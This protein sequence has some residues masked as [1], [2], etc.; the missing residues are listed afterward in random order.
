[1]QNFALSRYGVK[2]LFYLVDPADRSHLILLLYLCFDRR[3]RDKDA[4]AL[5][6]KG[7]HQRTVIELGNHAWTD[8]ML[9]QPL[10][11]AGA[12]LV[13]TAG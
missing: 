13:T 5:L 6:P 4:F 10:V 9:V 7:L 12:Q 1:V 8:A 2:P 11:D 3:R